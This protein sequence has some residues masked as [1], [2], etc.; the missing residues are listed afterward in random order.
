MTGRDIVKAL[1]ESGLLDR[2]IE[3]FDYDI[4]EDSKNHTN[5]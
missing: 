4:S 2:E 5:A 3:C 1:T